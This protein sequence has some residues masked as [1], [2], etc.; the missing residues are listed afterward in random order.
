MLQDKLLLLDQNA[1]WTKNFFLSLSGRSEGVQLFFAMLFTNFDWTWH[2]QQVLLKQLRPSHFKRVSNFWCE[3]KNG[4]TLGFS[5]F[6]AW[7]PSHIERGLRCRTVVHGLFCAPQS[8]KALATPSA[9][10]KFNCYSH[11]KHVCVA[12]TSFICEMLI[13]FW[14]RTR[15]RAALSVARAERGSLI[16]YLL[17]STNVTDLR[18]HDSLNERPPPPPTFHRCCSFWSFTAVICF[19]LASF[20]IYIISFFLTKKIGWQSLPFIQQTAQCIKTPPFVFSFS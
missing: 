1:G 20:S 6:F 10:G 9:P 2:V 14:P 11:T 8:T 7:R 15:Q 19:I 17:P 5:F 16:S 18:L 4:S 13:F 12:V 3:K